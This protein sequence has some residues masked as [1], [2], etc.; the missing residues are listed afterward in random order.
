MAADDN[1]AVQRRIDR[2]ALEINELRRRTAGGVRRSSTR[3]HY[4]PI[5]SDT[6]NARTKGTTR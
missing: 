1:D 6:V 5:I 2:R 3:V 4:L